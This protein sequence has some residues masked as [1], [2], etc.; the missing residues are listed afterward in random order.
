MNGEEKTV[1][2]TYDHSVQGD[3]V[4]VRAEED[5]VTIIG[6][7]RGKDTRL[8]HN[9]K[10]DVGEVIIL[11]FTEHISGIKIRGQA[12]IFTKYGTLKSGK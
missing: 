12:E 6:L 9:E 11:Q 4:A 7:T 8:H 10:M 3:Y 1:Q 2:N 5:G